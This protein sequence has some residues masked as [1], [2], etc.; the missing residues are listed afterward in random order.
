MNRRNFFRLLTGAAVTPVLAP[1]AKLFPTVP[2]K[3]YIQGSEAVIGNYADY[4]Q[5]SDFIVGSAI[6]YNVKFAVGLP[7]NSNIRV[8]N[9]K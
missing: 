1:L 7:P 2:E 4:L 3:T 6:S 9:V 5:V 8:R